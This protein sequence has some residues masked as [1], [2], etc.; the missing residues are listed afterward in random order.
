MRRNVDPFVSLPDS[1]FVKTF[2]LSKDVVKEIAADLTPL[3]AKERRQDGISVMMKILIALTF[4]ATGSYQTL[5]GQS[6]IHNVSQK[7]VS[8]A[9]RQVTA[10]LNDARIIQKYLKWP[11]Q[12]TERTAIKARFYEIFKIPGVLGCIDGTHIA[13]LRP[14][15]HEERYFNR[16]G[17][18]SLNVMIICDSELNILCVDASTPG[19]AHDSNVWQS[20]PLCQHLTEAARNGDH[21][22]LLGDS[23]YPL[24][25][26]MVTPILNT[27]EGTPQHNF[28]N[29]HVT[30]RNCV[31]RCIGVLKARFRCLLAARA[32]H[33]DPIMAGKIVNACCVLHNIANKT[34]AP[35]PFLTPEEVEAEKQRQHQVG[36]QLTTEA[37]ILLNAINDDQ[38][39]R[40]INRDLLEGRAFQ[41]ALVDR[42][43]RERY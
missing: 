9:L 18:H 36:N 26:T 6:A 29:L 8:R 13:I 34:G 22:F 23:G 39:N 1:E 27:V 2:R 12:S 31:E 24:R 16:K 43:W 15:E 40:R 35:V 5:V 19:S 38:R 37:G 14:I 32:L 7:T 3:I 20:H 30:A 4:Y 21:V 10:A 25:R 41:Q 28:Y 11:M 33:Y 17:Y 42:L